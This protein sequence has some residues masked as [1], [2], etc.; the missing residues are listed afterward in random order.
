MER[1]L[2]EN[3]N[4]KETVD[5]YENMIKDLESQKTKTDQ[6]LRVANEL[7]TSVKKKGP[8]LSKEELEDFSSG[9]DFDNCNN[10]LITRN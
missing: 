8:Q 3:V 1:L 4:L 7:L 10:S 9:F 5:R 6:E 2:E